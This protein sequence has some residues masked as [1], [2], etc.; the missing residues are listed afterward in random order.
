MKNKDYI[1]LV[2]F[3]QNKLRNICADI[4][5]YKSKGVFNPVYCNYI[6]N[7]LSLSIDNLQALKDEL[8]TDAEAKA[9]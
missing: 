8:T 5:K 3:I 9:E 4:N 2:M 6:L 1:D 7:D